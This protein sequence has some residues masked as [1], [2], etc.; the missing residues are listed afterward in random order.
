[1][2]GI[3]NYYLGHISN[4]N[5]LNL[6]KSSSANHAQNAVLAKSGGRCLYA[7][8]TKRWSTQAYSHVCNTVK[9]LINAIGEQLPKIKTFIG[10][11][12]IS[13]KDFEFM[14]YNGCEI[15]P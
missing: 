11:G 13:L 2:W 15:I 7:N 9:N 6:K 1:M 14:K 5:R 4:A 3:R 12:K 8:I 10:N